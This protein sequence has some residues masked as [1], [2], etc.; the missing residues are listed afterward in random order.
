MRGRTVTARLPRFTALA[1]ITIQPCRSNRLL[2]CE[3]GLAVIA[4]E[5]V[6]GDA[7]DWWR[8]AEGGVRSAVIVGGN[9]GVHGV[10]ALVAGLE[11]LG[12]G[13]FGNRSVCPT[14]R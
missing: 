14:L 8:S 7:L 5:V 10:A 13:P 9:P 12:V 2:S 11:R 1:T 3:E 6:P 4:K